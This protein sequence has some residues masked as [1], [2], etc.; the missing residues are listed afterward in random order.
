MK[1]PCVSIVLLTF[2]C[3]ISFSQ[4]PDR[5]KIVPPSPDAAALGKYGN[6]PVSMYTGIPE[7]SVPLHTC[8][9]RDITIP[10]KLSYHSSGVQVAEEASWV[11]MGW[12]LSLNAVITR[13]VK[14]KDDLQTVNDGYSNLQSNSYKGYPFDRILSENSTSE[15][16]A[17]YLSDLCNSNLDEEPDIFYFNFLGKSGRFVLEQGQDLQSNYIIATV[18]S[19]EK[20]DIKY[21]RTSAQWEVRTADGFQYQFKT[22]EVQENHP[23]S[24]SFNGHPTG[25]YSDPTVLDYG[26]LNNDDV[27]VSAWY[28]DKIIS[29]LGN[30]VTFAYDVKSAGS[31]LPQASY[32]GSAKTSYTD[33]YQLQL[34]STGTCGAGYTHEP[35]MTNGNIS[36]TQHVYL[37]EI[38]LGPQKIVIKKS[39]RDD[40]CPANYRDEGISVALMNV[41]YPN[42]LAKGPQRADSVMVVDSLSG[43]VLKKIEFDYTYFNADYSG[44]NAWLY[45]RLKLNGVRVC[46]GGT[47]PQCEPYTKFYYDESVA[48]PSKYSRGQ[49]F[50]GYYNGKDANP[51]NVPFGSQVDPS[52]LYITK[53]GDADRWPD[54]SK[55]KAGI[56]TKIT[57]PTGGSTEMQ[58][59]PHD[60]SHY[61]E[62]AFKLTDWE[63]NDPVVLLTLSSTGISATGPSVGYFYL[64][65]PTR[66]SISSTITYRTCLTS[67]GI[68]GAPNPFT[69][70]NR[71][72]QQFNNTRYNELSTYLSVKNQSGFDFTQQLNMY[73]TFI[74]EQWNNCDNNRPASCFF[75][76]EPTAVDFLMQPGTYTVTINNYYDFDFSVK[77]KKHYV[78]P[79]VIP[80]NQDGISA[81]MASGFRIKTIVDKES[82]QD[83]G[84]VK[85]FK[86][87]DDNRVSTGRL[88]LYPSYHSIAAETWTVPVG[89][90][91]CTQTYT[92]FK[93]SSW[94]NVPLG[95]SAQGSIVGYDRVTVYDGAGAA[96]GKSEFYYSNVEETAQDMGGLNFIEGLPTIANTSNGMLEHEKH[97]DFSGKLLKTVDYVNNLQLH[98]SITGFIHRTPKNYSNFINYVNCMQNTELF[99]YKINIE[100]NIM[101]EKA[102]ESFA[103]NA[104]GQIT[105]SLKTNTKNYYDVTSHLQL[106]DTYVTSS[107]GEEIQTHFTYF[108]EA[109]WIPQQM[110]D[111]EFRHGVVVGR[112]I[113]RNDPNVGI[114]GDSKLTSQER[115]Y[116][117]ASPTG[118]SV[119]DREEKA[120]G[121]QPFF[122]TVSFKFTNEGNVAE[123]TA[124]DGV[125]TS[126]IWGHAYTLPIAKIDGAPA[127]LTYYTGFEDYNEGN[128]NVSKVGFKGWTGSFTK[129]VT[130]LIAGKYT[131]TYWSKQGSNDWQLNTSTI[132]LAAGTTSY[133]IT[134]GSSAL[135]IDDVR[136]YPV[137]AKM[138]TFSYDALGN[139]VAVTDSN[140]LSTKYSYDPLERLKAVRDNNGFL[141]KTFQYNYRN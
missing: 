88:M 123:H 133:N 24:K 27:Y 138:T 118:K 5:Q 74:T 43:K 95:T 53:L 89:D 84:H 49:D 1:S 105:S 110:K 65:E 112:T 66:I 79:R 62:S 127:N 9:Y 12:T 67:G 61:G 60:F 31:G 70:E 30:K 51:T 139:M 68:C 126:Y 134:I 37:S 135:I 119:I 114:L 125:T 131:L 78:R 82:P 117:A 47:A 36:F 115:I 132:T 11:G 128:S 106:Q 85:T 38:N 64:N 46:G 94:P 83:P 6:I 73:Q 40:M 22:M 97:Y 41:R 96:D 91:Y 98:R 69:G 109:S 48:L 34:S 81:K 18:T 57:Y 103:Y 76:N 52:T 17:L 101:L 137:S 90:S 59:E 21:N 10:I 86:Y 72:H 50:W 104:T 80:V 129:A 116:Y 87:I 55:A 7:I 93:S 107:R 3:H 121:D 29:P 26:F 15:E 108:N 44:A 39:L 56:L 33:T 75:D 124:R 136:F 35:R 102:E 100:R 122:K 25:P 113:Y 2:F 99:P 141:K 54:P 19:V 111:S 32:Y 130:N 13:T 77:I 45:K 120:N 14:G 58:Y 140:N 20:I 16:Y 63:K 4:I 8:S 28:L 42:P 92:N 71:D 23:G